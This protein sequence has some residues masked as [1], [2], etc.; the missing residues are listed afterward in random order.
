MALLQSAFL[1]AL[2]W[3]LIDSLWQM[4]ILWMLYLLLTRGGQQFSARL[5]H[6]LALLLTV[7]GTLA[8]LFSFAY[9]Y[10]FPASAR[11]LYFSDGNGFTT[12][13]LWLT[14]A[15]SASLPYLSALYL[16]IVLFLLARFLRQYQYTTQILKDPG[17]KVPAE[18]RVFLQQTAARLG[19][20]RKIRLSLSSRISSPLTLGFWKPVILLPVTSLNQLT[21]A[22]AEAILLHEL[23]HI[24]SND[25]AVNLL[26]SVLHLLLFFNPFAR[27]L[28]TTVI[29]ER[30]NHCDDTV[31]NF[32]FNPTV[33]AEALLL[34][35]QQRT[36]ALALAA[37]GNNPK[38]LLQ[39]IERILL[40]KPAPVQRMRL[41][42]LVLLFVLLSTAAFFAPVIRTTNARTAMGMPLPEVQTVAYQPQAETPLRRIATPTIDPNAI[43]GEEPVVDSVDNYQLA[44]SEEY[45]RE[46]SALQALA[47]AEKE[48]IQV[49]ELEKRDYALGLASG[50][51][52]EEFVEKT[53][54][55]VPGNS[56]RYQ[57]LEDT[58]PRS[59]AAVNAE[60]KS[61]ADLEKALKAL[62]EINWK[63]LEA[64]MKSQDGKPDMVALH[65]QI[66]KAL[67]QVDWKK[68]E[69][70][71][72]NNKKQAEAQ[73]AL[74][75]N[76]LRQLEEY[77]LQQ[78]KRRKLLKQQ[79]ALILEQRLNETKTGKKVKRVVVI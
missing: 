4:G 71:I 66:K 25:Y 10:F 56:F 67:Q 21:T 3:S 19:I 9:H 79:Q 73:L 2:G 6:N 7:T 33:Y 31:L 51:E 43:A 5:R 78:E 40:G 17:A 37:N 53:E 39:R 41:S 57:L 47:E 68:L 54:P 60:A 8:F 18:L 32:R 70:E 30:E 34:L 38:I 50:K 36:P 74:N 45:L 26:L 1:T 42:G 52:E 63:E 44:L 58:L 64:E 27:F 11:P 48:K 35:E 24:R 69:T 61:R 62:D 13:Y 76:Y 59:S 14:T 29:R 23:Q 49:Q 55:Y 46:W 15:L 72:E 12:V 22:Q 28:C 20:H 16:L 77:R 65:E 75:E